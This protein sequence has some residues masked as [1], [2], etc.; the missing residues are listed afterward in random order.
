MNWISFADR[1]PE[2]DLKV[3]VYIPATYGEFFICKLSKGI[4][5]IHGRTFQFFMD[6]DSGTWHWTWSLSKENKWT[7]LNKSVFE[8]MPPKKKQCICSVVSNMCCGK[9]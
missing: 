8:I 3:L 2:P 4:A 1:L 9:E 7:Y 6:C 5:D